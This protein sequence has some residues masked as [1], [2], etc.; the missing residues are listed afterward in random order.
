MVASAPDE[1]GNIDILVNNAG[2]IAEAIFDSGRKIST[3]FG[4]QS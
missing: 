1:F 3:N 2:I 4:G